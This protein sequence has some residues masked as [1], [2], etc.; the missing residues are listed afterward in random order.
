M[1]SLLRIKYL[2]FLEHAREKGFSSAVAFT[3]YKYEEAV[4][5]EKDLATLKPLPESTETDLRLLDLGP[6]NFAGYCLDYPLASRRQRVERYFRCGYRS[7]AMVRGNRVLADLWYVTR[8]SAR[9]PGIHPHVQWFGID[10]GP[11]MAYMFDMHFLPGQRG[12][13]AATFFMGSALHHLRDRGFIR[14]YG[15]F[16]AHNTPALWVH[17][18]LGWRELPRFD[19]QRFLLYETA[20]PKI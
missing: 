16:A 12:G 3:L 18:L 15:Y 17:R 10:L 2:Q 20:K 11:H 5:V 1:L 19:V 13:G 7:L 9:T 14:A 4:P 6:E 8:D